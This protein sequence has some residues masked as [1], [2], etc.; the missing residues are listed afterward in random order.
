MVKKVVA[1]GGDGIGP[2]VVDATVWLLNEMKISNLE[3]ISMP[4]GESAI[5][6]HGTAFPPETKQAAQNCDAIL[7][8]ATEEKAL[9]V[10]AFLRWGLE[11]YANIRPIK[12]YPGIEVVSPL[13]KEL[14]ENIDYVFVREGTEGMYAAAGREGKVKK[15]VR[16]GVVNPA[17]LERWG[18]KA[19]YALR[20]CS[21][22]GTERIARFALEL[23]KKRKEEGI[24]KGLFY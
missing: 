7:F 15:L 11:N 12:Y 9:Q 10:I 5:E 13:K 6:T 23:C 18:E 3:I 20:I 4:V 19:I 24:G 2:L 16:K 8:G 14:I 22:E 1:L 17:E 21:P